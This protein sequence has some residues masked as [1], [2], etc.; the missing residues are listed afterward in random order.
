MHFILLGCAIVFNATANILMKL[1]AQRIGPLT[2]TGAAIQAFLINPFIWGGLASFGLALIFYTYVLT[3]MNLSVAYPLMTALGFL[4][5]VTFSAFY[6]QE[7]IHPPQI[8][9]LVLVI[10]GLYLIAQ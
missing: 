5:V 4:I 6:L 8:L 2:S 1:G 7:S 3:K 9:G 10:G